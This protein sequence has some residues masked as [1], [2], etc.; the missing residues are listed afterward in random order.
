MD[1]QRPF[2]H[3]A[4]AATLLAAALL[5]SACSPGRAVESPGRP[6]GAQSSITA[7]PSTPHRN[8]GL[9]FSRAVPSATDGS[10]L[11]AVVRG[12]S[13]Q[14]VVGPVVVRDA[15]Y[16]A[17]PSW[18]PDGLSFAFL[19]AHG[20]SVRSEH[21]TR[22]IVACHPQTC[23]GLGAP[24]WSPTASSIAFS[25]QIDGDE[26]LFQVA[27]EGG[28]PTPIVSNLVVAGA[29][30]W[31]PDGAQLAAIVAE[32]GTASLQILD[33][34][35][36]HVQRTIEL[37]GLDLGEAVTWSPDG[38]SL[39][40]EVTGSEQGEH[41]GIYLV[42]FDGTDPQLLTACPDADCVDLVPSFSPDGMSVVFTRGRCDE[43]GSD[44]FVGDV[45]VIRTDGGNAHALTHGPGLDCCAAWRPLPS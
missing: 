32:G 37:P 33:A 11:H 43:P 10:P 41:Q 4:T 30:A 28:E 21:D 42:A 38:A 40:V 3:A 24:S 9:V 39:A 27:P 15:A 29:P 34:E 20:I 31:S 19:G 8:G 44:C 16:R 12:V 22:L 14:G 17:A 25:G 13:V 6:S 23:S 18:A 26:G 35:S 7:P 1:T 45:W 36:G 2:L 5:A